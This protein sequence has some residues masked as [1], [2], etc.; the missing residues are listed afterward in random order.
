[1]LLESDYSEIIIGR[2]ILG[3]AFQYGQCILTGFIVTA[4]FD[5]GIATGQ[6]Y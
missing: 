6:T 2:E 5:Q 1:M 4:T 3:I